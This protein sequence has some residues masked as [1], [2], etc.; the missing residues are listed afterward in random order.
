MLS[1]N[2]FRF[3]F[4]A[5]T[6]VY[7]AGL[8]VDVINVDAAQYASISKEMLQTGSYLVVKH[9]GQD[10]LDKPPLLF[11]LSALSFKIFG[12]HNW[13]YKLPSFL[14]TLLGVF[15]TFR[16]GTVLYD[17]RVGKLAALLLYTC[18]AFFMFNNDVRTDTILTACV[19]TSIWLLYEFSENNK[20]S[21]LIGGSVFVALGMM[22]KGPIGIVVPVLALGLH[23]VL[24]REWKQLFRPA[25]F[26]L[27]LFVLI[28][29][30]PMCYGLYEQYGWH[31]VKFFFWTQSFG[32]ITGENVWRNDAGY[33]F[34][35]HTFLWS[36]MP[37]SVLAVYA[38]G[39]TIGAFIKRR[40]LP[41]YLTI[42]G[43]VLT[44]IA[45]SMS[46]YKLPHYIFVVFPLIAI[47]TAEV[48]ETQ[49]VR[50]E[51]LSKW[52]GSIHLLFMMIYVALLVLIFYVFK[53]ENLWLPTVTVGLI[54]LS[55]YLYYIKLFNGL[56]IPLAVAAV[57]L[58]FAMNT[59]LYPH[60][61][62]YQPAKH[63]ANILNAEA[64]N[65]EVFFYEN[66]SAAFDYYFRSDVQ[67]FN[68][69]I[70]N[71]PVSERNPVWIYSETKSFPDKL[72]EWSI[73]PLNQFE[74][75]FYHIQFLN[76]KFLN[77][78]TRATTL[79][80]AYLVQI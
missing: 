51:K 25:W 80:K 65:D 64:D 79:K 1:K 14:F 6:I 53:I 3:V 66:K 70:L 13:S 33:F 44:F 42:G 71:I 56:I 62:Q 50:N 45:L 40:T 43:F 10:Y 39:D 75:D 48:I 31:G 37:W 17:E 38:L 49:I 23:F 77:P 73:K 60:L 9:C 61:L 34:F 54:L 22:A 63:A 19:I 41:E 46:K 16:L 58:N 78:K 29:L 69:N 20:W 36:F 24:K 67:Y 52:L 7:V 68:E 11:W 32:R 30:L 76:W 74:F 72:N 4:I 2:I 27:L 26:L 55:A 47:L 15:A 28:L 35:V 12:I 8:F 5:A 21:Y 57:A 59:H 18:Q